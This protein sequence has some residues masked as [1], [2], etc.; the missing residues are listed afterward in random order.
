MAGK[1]IATAAFAV[2][3]V[4]NG[5]LIINLFCKDSEIVQNGQ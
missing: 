3:S 2:S 5:A 4:T 1:V